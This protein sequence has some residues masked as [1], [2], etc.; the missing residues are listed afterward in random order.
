MVREM[1]VRM[2]FSPVTYDDDLQNDLDFGGNSRRGRSFSC[3]ESCYLIS[4]K[5]L[6][7]RFLLFFRF[8]DGRRK[9]AMLF[10]LV[11]PFGGEVTDFLEKLMADSSLD[12][13]V[14]IAEKKRKRLHRQHNTV[15]LKVDGLVISA[16][17][18]LS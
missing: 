18:H 6:L 17:A 11:T 12:Y 10:V 4:L 13:S 9:R 15:L 5:Y 16:I 1:K 7:I 3:Q 14:L 8:E 2:I